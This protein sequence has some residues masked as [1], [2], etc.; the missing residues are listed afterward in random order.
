MLSEK[1]WICH[2]DHIEVFAI[3]FE[4][5]IIFLF[6]VFLITEVLVTL[7]L[8]QKILIELTIF[9]LNVNLWRLFNLL[10]Y[11]RLLLMTFFGHLRL[12]LF[13]LL[14]MLVCLFNVL[15][16]ID[17]LSSPFLNHLIFGIL[18]LILGNL[19]IHDFLRRF[20]H[21]N[22]LFDDFWLFW[23]FF[24]LIL[25][26][27]FNDF[28]LIWDLWEHNVVI[29]YLWRSMHIHYFLNWMFNNRLM[30]N[31]LLIGLSIVVNLIFKVPIRLIDILIL[32]W[33][34]VRVWLL[35][36]KLSLNIIIH[37]DLLNML[38]FMHNDFFLPNIIDHFGILNDRQLFFVF[39]HL[40]ANDFKIW[41]IIDLLRLDDLVTVNI[42]LW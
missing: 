24:N 3:L 31:W 32:C 12:K 11:Y 5:V 17:F 1:N 37:H 38:S 4:S 39:L 30:I 14:N 23:L 20:L 26:V 34:S 40:I 28:T 41:D 19:V 33:L 25:F 35:L 16:L 6:F 13:L 9:T 22:C 27:D 2:R 10:F 42:W 7:L 29:I 8:L 18:L 21:D 15:D 36:C